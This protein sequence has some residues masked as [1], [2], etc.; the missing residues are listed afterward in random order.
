MPRI[1]Q[2]HYAGLKA[3]DASL[4]LRDPL[5]LL[6]GPVGAG[7][8]SA[9]EALRFA[10]LGFVPALGRSEAATAR[11]LRHDR[12]DVEVHLDDGRHFT[13]GLVREGAKLRSEAFASWLPAKTGATEAGAAITALFGASSLEAAE[14]LDL[15]E[16]LTATP[17]TRSKRIEQLLDSSG[18]APEVLARRGW[19]LT[20]LRLAELPSERIP[21]EAEAAATLAAACEATIP[22]E[23][24][25]AARA[26]TREIEEL[27]RAAGLAVAQERVRQAKLDATAA[28]R[29]KVAARGEI[30]DRAVAAASGPTDTVQVLQ[31]K[32]DALATAKARA[33]RDLEEGARAQ[34][35]RLETEEALPALREAVAVAERA[36]AAA[37]EALPRAEQARRE[38]A[39]LVDPPDVVAPAAMPPDPA[40]IAEA[41]RF[42]LEAQASYQAGQAVVLPERL[43]AER[44]KVTL[45]VAEEKL[46]AAEKSPWRRVEQIADELD[47][48]GGRQIANQLREL[49]DEHGGSVFNLAR[50]LDQARQQLKEA[51][52]QIEARDGEIATAKAERARLLASAEELRARAL[53]TRSAAVAAAQSAERLARGTYAEAFAAR[54]RQVELNRQ[55]R[56]RLLQEASYHEESARAAQM[57]RDRARTDL[58][59]VEQRLAGI[60]SVSV[61]LDGA[62]KALETS[63]QE[64]VLLDARLV[65]L[66]KAEARRQEMAA[67]LQEIDRATALQR[68]YAAA[69]W[70]CERLRGEDLAARATGIEGRMR[71]FLQA[72]GRTEE[73]Y[74]RANKGGAEFGLRRDGHEIAVEALSG[75]EHVLYCAALAATVIALRAPA[76]RVLLVE[77]AELGAGEVAQALLRGCTAIAGELQVVVATN[78]AIEP[79]EGWSVLRC[80]AET[81]AEVVA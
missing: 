22:K 60:A 31:V 77:A 8:S 46:R 4:S 47:E 38:A 69:E 27:L 73:P 61:D 53:G 11:L 68:A 30:E 9:E 29:S 3:R 76:V 79:P 65:E 14:G 70:A 1:V 35:T 58:Q 16:L 37:L 62:A 55:H 33:E 34:R 39:A 25:G 6:L 66:R 15:R 21:P 49:A 59:G 2:L 36:Q 51:R 23:I 71:G 74:L 64:L 19:A 12:L 78:A 56:N 67:L 17:A 72:A 43:S 7:K 24:Q 40:E 57:A 26:V 32:R 44:E 10:A 5:T 52:A 75:G 48:L 54:A 42:L 18:L 20:L 13:R 50:V 41:D 63:R 80:G 28:V 81:A 45:E